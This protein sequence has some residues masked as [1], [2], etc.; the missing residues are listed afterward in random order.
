MYVGLTDGA[1]DARVPMEAFQLE[2]WGE[3]VTYHERL[4][5]VLL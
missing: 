1:A 5:D 4:K 2:G 3:D